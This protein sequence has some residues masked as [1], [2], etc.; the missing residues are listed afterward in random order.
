MY[1]PHLIYPYGAHVV[2]G[3]VITGSSSDS[4]SPAS[5][6]AFSVRVPPR[7]STQLH[8]GQNARHN[9][10]EALTSLQTS[11]CLGLSASNLSKFS[12]YTPGQQWL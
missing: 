5:T 11:T 4:P 6:A 1:M 2:I 8:T 10:C 3:A 12:S 7:G 9:C